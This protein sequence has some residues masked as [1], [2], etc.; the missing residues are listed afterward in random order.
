MLKGKRFFAGALISLLLC[1]VL[2]VTPVLATDIDMENERLSGT[3]RYATSAAIS[4]S[5]WTQASTVIIATGSG[6]ADAL[7]ASSLS[8]SKDAPILLC[9]KSAMSQDIVAELK[10]LKATEAILVGGTGVIGAGVENQLK[11]LGIGITRIGG[12]DRY[13]TSKKVAETMGVN[14]GIIMATGYNFPDALSIAP[15]AGIKSIPILLSPKDSMTSSIA[16]FIKSKSITVSFI[17]GQSGVISNS[18]AEDL[19]NSKRLG[20]NDRYATNLIINKN[21]EKDLNFD[22]IYL[23]TGNDFPDALAGS[24]LAAKNNAPIFLSRKDS[25]DSEIINYLKSKNVKKVVVL[26]G[27]DVVSDKVLDDTVKSLN[28]H[29]LTISLNK[30]T[31]ILTVGGTDTLL[32]TVAPANVTN[33]DVAWTS[34]NPEIATVDNTGKVTAVSY[35][36]TTITSTT[37]NG[38]TATCKV[39]VSNPTVAVTTILLNRYYATLSVGDTDTYSETVVP[40]NATNKNVIWTSSNPEIAT[41]DNT[42]K[43]TGI[44]VGDTII[45]VTSTTN[46]NIYSYCRL[47][48]NGAKATSIT[49]NK[50]TDNMLTGATG[51]LI[52]TIKPDYAQNKTVRWASNNT[53]TATVDA[54][55]KVT[56]IAAG[57]VVIS[58]QTNDG[59]NIV[60]SYVITITDPIINVTSVSLDNTEKTMTTDESYYFNVTVAPSNATN[61]DVTWTSSNPEVAYIS[62]VG[63]VTSASV[64]TTTITAT[65]VDGSKTASCQ[66][67]VKINVASV[68]LNKTTDYILVGERI[69]DLVAVINPIDSTN[70][71]VIWTSSNPSVATV[72]SMGIVTSASA[73]TATITVTTVDGSKSDNCNV[74]VHPVINGLELNKPYKARDGMT[75]MVNSIEKNE[76]VGSIKYIVSYTL[77]NETTDNRID[78]DSFRMY[79]EDGT[80]LPQYGYFSYL[81]PA[82]SLSR[83]YTFEVLKTKQP[84]LIEYGV[85]FFAPEPSLDTLK[86]EVR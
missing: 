23:A 2:N 29:P 66:V 17:V 46:E 38:V 25:I 48:V 54:T 28:V 50:D 1:G 9:Q 86:W 14:N 56:A 21:F 76:E 4:K 3:N 41:V 64:G 75:V 13:D 12:S 24:A 61:K 55:G 60:D 62:S 39:T 82:Q 32:A 37:I 15:I 73:G 42:G 6:Y 65:S 8:K 30:T 10:R 35:G 18:I 67:T 80:T 59:T 45:R 20:G 11:S 57:I 78:E 5:G 44:G 34:L 40:S 77:R 27:S 51:T 79:F 69:D 53:S 36:T 16:E 72:D 22:T 84:T 85:D 70:K 58:A 71:D 83:V 49:I 81:S 26:G 63:I 68:S 7:A 74:V 43:V 47:T 52:A 19:P 33:K 31:D